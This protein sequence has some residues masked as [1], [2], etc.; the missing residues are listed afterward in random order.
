M[1]W[2][3][4]VNTVRQF[5]CDFFQEFHLD[6]RL[7]TKETE[8]NTADFPY[9]TQVDDFDEWN[10]FIPP[11]EWEDILPLHPVE[12]IL[13]EGPLLPIQKLEFHSKSE[14]DVLF[15]AILSLHKEW[16]L[17]HKL[18]TPERILFLEKR[19]VANALKI[20]TRLGYLKLNSV[21]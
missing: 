14:V 1:I 20:A 3:E 12:R 11:P 8:L 5:H 2:G 15:A 10:E 13:V 17:A 18:S 19:C 16:C 4:I 21:R 6:P 7:C 9:P